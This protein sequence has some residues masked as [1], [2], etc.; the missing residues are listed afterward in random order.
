MSLGST[1]QSI[2]A[3]GTQPATCIS[4]PPAAPERVPK[5]TVDAWT[6]DTWDLTGALLSYSVANPNPSPPSPFSATDPLAGN[7]IYDTAS[8]CPGLGGTGSTAYACL[9]WGSSFTPRPRVT[10]VSPATGPAAGGTSVTLS[11]DGFSAASA[12]YFGTTPAASYTVNNDNS[13]TAV[14]A[15]DTSGASPDTMDMAVASAGGTSFT[16]TNDQYTFYGQPSVTKVSPNRGPLSGGYYVT[17][18]GTNFV[19]TTAVNDG[20]TPTAFQVINNSTLSVYIVPGESAGDQIGITVTSLGGTGPATPA[21]QFTYSPPAKVAVSPVKGLPGA[22]VK[23]RGAHFANGETVKVKY[24]T[25]LSAPKPTSVTICT[26]TTTASGAFACQGK[27]PGVATAGARGL[28]SIVAT[29]AI[30]DFAG[31]T[32]DLT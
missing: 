2:Q 26:G 14:S 24:L 18:T 16:S 31:T 1:T 23:V 25:G 5:F 29:G 8:P 21:D 32:F 15:A 19:G 13:I 20:D 11:G 28:H 17:V 27:I 12:V 4:P 7:Q 22:T 6:A 30:G 10:G 3:P 9:Q